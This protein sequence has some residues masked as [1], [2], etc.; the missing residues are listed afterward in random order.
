MPRP[1]AFICA[2]AVL[3]MPYATVIKV[4]FLLAPTA[5]LL[6]LIAAYNGVRRG[7]TPA[8][9]FMIAWTTLMVAAIIATLFSAGIIEQYASESLYIIEFGAFVE[10]ILLSI[11][12]ASRIRDL[13]QDSLTDG[14]TQLFNRR[15]FD[16]QLLR[17]AE[18]SQRNSEPLSLLI[19]D[20]DHFKQFNDN[21]GHDVGDNVLRQ[22]GVTLLKAARQTDY[23]CRYGGEEFTILLPNTDKGN[24][25]EIAERARKLIS[26]KN[27]KESQITV[28]I[29]L[30]TINGT[31]EVNVKNL[32]KQADEALYRAKNS[33]RNRVESFIDGVA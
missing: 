30:A 27:I 13:E 9:Y 23:I 19:I 5:Y 29:G 8:R 12:L 6:I 24:A 31:E 28:S 17:L 10:M 1:F 14:L 26:Q 3:F 16:R 21:F 18:V 22:V 15:F 25:I 2:F 32:L 11:A 33:G 7:Y 20:I 4:L